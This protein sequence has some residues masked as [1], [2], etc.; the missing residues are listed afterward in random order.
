MIL[1]QLI[2]NIKKKLLKVKF[3]ETSPLKDKIKQNWSKC[4]YKLKFFIKEYQYQLFYVV[5]L[6]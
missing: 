1:L 3:V 6:K 2:W 5:W 4:A